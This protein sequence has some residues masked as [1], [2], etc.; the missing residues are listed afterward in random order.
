MIVNLGR[1]VDISLC[2]SS[3]SST[4]IFL[5]G[6][7]LR[8]RYCQNFELQSGYT[9]VDIIEVI[10]RIEKNMGFISSVIFSGGEPLMQQDA[11]QQLLRHCKEKGLRTGIETSGFY[12]WSLEELFKENLLDEV[13]IDFKTTVM[14]YKEFTGN[15]W[16]YSNMINSLF[17]CSNYRVPTE[18]RTTIFEGEL[19]EEDMSDM[20]SVVD[21]FDF[22]W[23]KQ[24]GRKTP[25]L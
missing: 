7:P 2:D 15:V 13:F 14:K 16:A 1:V 9:P 11:L 22:K 8:C 21:F 25:G 24:N 18:I 20:K 6:C 12:P 10:H 5:R 3:Y 19:T 23:R 17:Q 4:I